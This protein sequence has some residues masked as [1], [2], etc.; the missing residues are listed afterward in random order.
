MSAAP[1]RVAMVSL[2]CPKNQVDAE[3]MLGLLQNDG[4]VLCGEEADADAIIVNTCA[5]IEDAKQEAIETILE[6]A[7]YKTE[8]RCRALIVTGC[9]SERYRDEVTKEMPEVDLA[10]GLGSVSRIAE[11][12]RALLERK[13]DARLPNCY[14]EKSALPLSG[15]RRLGG[16]PFTAYLKIAEGCDNACSYC[17]IP[18]IRGR[19]R[20]RSIEDIVAEAKTLCEGGVRELVVVAQDTTAYGVDLWGE[21]RL[22]E[23][24]EALCEVEGAH[25]IRLLYAYPDRIDDRLL[26]VIK[27][28]AQLLPYLDLPLQH[29]DAGLLRRMNR[30]G[31]RESL[32]ALIAHIRDV[33]PDVTL[34]TTLITGF[35]GE[36]DAQ[37]AELCEFVREIGFDRLGCFAYSPEEGTVAAGLPDQIDEQTRQDRAEAILQ[38]QLTILAKRNEAKIGSLQEVLVEGYD[39][40]IR[41]WFG[42]SRADAP[43]VDGKVFFAADRPVEIG[44]FVRVR[45]ND[46]LDYDLLG[47]LEDEPAQ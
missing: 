13:D 40:Y 23:L 5:F 34:R 26:H 8:G 16:E 35:P 21:S 25:W 14:G 44:G 24:L 18:K 4:F 37:F 11:L 10:V 36:T 9:L 19:L 38:D 29:C 39:S 2:G 22:P 17:A 33:L 46:C 20:S 45:I 28:H 30:I 6:V 43:E 42:R 27:T 7:K 1:Y 32:T 41:C 3:R 15:P 12:T 31:S 47:A